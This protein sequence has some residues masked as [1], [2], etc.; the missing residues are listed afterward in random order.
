MLLLRLTRQRCSLILGIGRNTSTRRRVMART[1]GDTAW[2]DPEHVKQAAEGS[3]AATDGPLAGNERRRW[4]ENDPS[5]LAG[6]A[7]PSHRF[8]FCREAQLGRWREDEDDPADEMLEV[9]TPVGDLRVQ[10]TRNEAAAEQLVRVAER[11]EHLRQEHCRVS[12]DLLNVVRH[13]LLGSWS[14]HYARD[15]AGGFVR[16]C[17]TSSG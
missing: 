4:R 17:P 2:P 5:L 3:A 16:S 6:E 14:G 1:N 13:R 9:A 15:W 10:M 11:G 7:A 8:G 12:P